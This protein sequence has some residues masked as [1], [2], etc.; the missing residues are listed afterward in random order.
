MLSS[1]SDLARRGRNSSKISEYS[2]R[3]EVTATYRTGGVGLPLGGGKR[4]L[5][6]ISK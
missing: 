5:G 1:S 3:G 4:S 6:K 2:D